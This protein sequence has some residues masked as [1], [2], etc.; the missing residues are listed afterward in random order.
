MIRSTRAI[1]VAIAVV[2][3]VSVLGA[4]GLLTDEP[5]PPRAAAPPPVQWRLVA[6]VV[7]SAGVPLRDGRLLSARTR[8]VLDPH[9]FPAQLTVAGRAVEPSDLVPADAAVTVEPGRDRVEPLAHRELPAQPLLSVV[10]GKR[11]LRLR[12]VEVTVGAVSGE[13]VRRRVLLVAPPVKPRWHG[14]V[15]LTFDDGPDPTWTPQ[16]L[17]LLKARGVHAVF[18]LVGR[19]VRKHPDLVRRILREGHSLCDHTENHDEH[20]P[21]EPVDVARLE[22]LRGADALRRATAVRPVWFRAPGG[23]WSPAVEQLVRAAGMVPLKW[24]VDPRDW[25]RPPARVIVSRVLAAA[26]P[27]GIVLLHDGGGDRRQSLVA[28]RSL[29]VALPR[30][31]LQFADP[32]PPPVPRAPAPT[33]VP[34]PS[35]EPTPSPSP[36][37]S[38]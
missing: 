18:C 34:S 25:E 15:L 21:A 30:I 23:Q 10:A 3:G 16:V 5:A 37:P 28:L 11:V 2:L 35:P 27:G 8:R 14:S 36:S 26:R 1:G 6:E 13:E 38:P 9:A 33:P 19:E 24:T 29:L 12:T 17:A 22:I 7:A 20:L 4:H 32:V 31:G